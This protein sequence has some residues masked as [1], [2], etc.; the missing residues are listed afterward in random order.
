MDRHEVDAVEL[1]VRAHALFGDGQE[2]RGGKA[3]LFGAVAWISLNESTEEVADHRGEQLVG[4]D[5][6]EATD[7]VTAEA[8]RALGTDL[9]I[10]A[11]ETER[12]L[13]AEDRE[14]PIARE[15]LLEP[16]EHRGDVAR[17]DI[18]RSEPGRDRSYGGDVRAACRDIRQSGFDL[19]RQRVVRGGR[20]VGALDDGDRPRIA[21]RRREPRRRKRAEARHSNAA[22][23]TSRATQL[24]D[25]G[26]GGVRDAPH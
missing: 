25:H 11:L 3:L 12:M 19:A 21:Q 17:G 18:A 10:H 9:E 15:W 8:I 13:D 6:A 24:V 4:R 22:D 16:A 14:T 2:V 23:T 20:L 26:D 7:R 1:G 5:G